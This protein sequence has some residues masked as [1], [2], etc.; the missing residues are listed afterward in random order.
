MEELSRPGPI[1]TT[2]A[3]RDVNAALFE[4]LFGPVIATFARGLVHAYRD[5]GAADGTEIAVRVTGAASQSMS[6]RR[7]VDRWELWSGGSATP[8]TRISIEADR[9]WRLWTKGLSAA[10][11][12][13]C[14]LIEG[15][16]RLALPLTRHV[17]IL[18]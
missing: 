10:E 8:A 12:E 9:A 16:W 6:L 1:D 18:A 14:L 4:L 5:C 15:E 7:D 13:R 3:F 2:K 17:A 11:G